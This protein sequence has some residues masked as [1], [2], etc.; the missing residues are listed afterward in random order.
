MP[1][2]PA[3]PIVGGGGAGS[4]AG[5]GGDGGDVPPLGG[6][7]GSL[8]ADGTM[9]KG[10][11]HYGNGG[12]PGD[13]DGGG[14]GKAGGDGDDPDGPNGKL[15]FDEN[16]ED[17]AQKLASGKLR[18]GTLDDGNGDP[19]PTAKLH[20]SRDFTYDRTGLPRYD[21]SVQG[22]TS[23]LTE[24]SDRPNALAS[25]CAIVTTSSFQSVVE[26]YR[27]HLPPGWRNQTIGDLQA[28]ANALSTQAI[29]NTLSGAPKSP[30]APAPPQTPRMQ[31]SMYFPPA[32]T[33][34]DLGIMIVQ[35]EGKAVTVL[36]KTHHE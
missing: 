9:K 15:H 23:A 7:R 17:I 33:P 6:G 8:E 18:P 29:I 30:D 24:Y 21:A 12:E 36:M 28:L 26:W 20:T 34:G 19:D 22:V 32:G 3:N 10:N 11:Q 14:K 35:Q 31:V 1:R 2:G 25:S 4:L 27:T 13:D 16:G 5:G